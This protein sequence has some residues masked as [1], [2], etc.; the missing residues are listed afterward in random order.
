MKKYL[1][2]GVSKMEHIKQIIPAIDGWMVDFNWEQVRISKDEITIRTFR[3]KAPIISFCVIKNI[4]REPTNNPNYEPFYNN[5]TETDALIY[6]EYRQSYSSV[7]NMIN[8]NWDND[9]YLFFT[10]KIYKINK[11]TESVCEG[12][13]RYPNEEDLNSRKY[14][15]ALEYLRRKE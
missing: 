12:W 15:R 14:Q 3:Q 10:S 13:S 11:K 9:T 7:N 8:S 4:K 6:D 5:F 1:K 2:E